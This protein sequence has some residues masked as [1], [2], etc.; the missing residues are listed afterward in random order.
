MDAVWSA[1]NQILGGFGIPSSV[2]NVI[3]EIFSFLVNFFTGTL[4]GLIETV[5]GWFA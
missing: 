1:I 5:S 4:P 2:G 3:A